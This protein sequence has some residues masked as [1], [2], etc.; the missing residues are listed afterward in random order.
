M[1]M[2]R[3]TKREY[4]IGPNLIIYNSFYSNSIHCIAEFDYYTLLNLWLF[5]SPQYS[6]FARFLIF[7]DFTKK[8]LSDF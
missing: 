1:K 7:L 5:L 4:F 2:N 3:L 8:R 6:V